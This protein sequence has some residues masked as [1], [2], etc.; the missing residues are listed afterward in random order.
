MTW[1]W[2]VGITS[3]EVDPVDKRFSEGGGDDDSPFEPGTF[4][5]RDVPAKRKSL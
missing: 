4:G 1:C 3:V 5:V 2:N